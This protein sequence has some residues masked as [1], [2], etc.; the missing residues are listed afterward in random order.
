[1]HMPHARSCR[2]A[3]AQLTYST[4]LWDTWPGHSSVVALSEAVHD[5][6]V[7]VSWFAPSTYRICLHT[8]ACSSAWALLVMHKYRCHACADCCSDQLC[9]TD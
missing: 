4:M 3:H 9:C 6:C 2:C 7:L 5:F 1:M 8:L